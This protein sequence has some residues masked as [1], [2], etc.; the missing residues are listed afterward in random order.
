M[1]P[2][3]SRS[4]GGRKRSVPS[5]SAGSVSNTRDSG[6]ASPKRA[7]TSVAAG[8]TRAG[9]TSTSR[10][11]RRSTGTAARVKADP[12]APPPPATGAPPAANAAET[13]ATTTATNLDQE[14]ISMFRNPSLTTPTGQITNT[15]IQQQF[16]PHRIT[17]LAATINGLTSRGRLT[18]S[19]HTTT[20]ELLYNLVS[21][22]QAAKFEGLDMSARLVYQIIERAGNMGIWTKDIRTQSNIQQLALNKIFKALES[23]RLIKPTKSVTAKAKKLYMLFDLMPAK[24]ITGGPWY[25]ELEFDHEFISELR[26]FI[27]HCVRRLNGGN[28]VS[29]REIMDKMTE[30]NVSRVRLSLGEIRQLVRTLVYD[31]MVEETAPAPFAA[32]GGSGRGGGGSGGREEELYVAARRVSTVCDFKWWDVVDPD[33]H[34]RQIKF[35]DGVTLAAHEPHHHT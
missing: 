10:S 8:A 1:A 33:F 18:M 29:L 2:T 12:D 3:G 21:E 15:T 34:F 14:F 32:V 24:E 17:A 4:S 16:G 19:R 13:A 6:T 9:N 26:H 5:G 11:G 22:S 28:G 31:Y 30:A 23:R 27:M 35:E 20:G 7:R 25:T